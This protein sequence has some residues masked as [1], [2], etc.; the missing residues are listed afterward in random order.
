V[1]ERVPSRNVGGD[2]RFREHQVVVVKHLSGDR[3]NPLVNRAQSD[4]APR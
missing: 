2:H 1:S 4:P 3:L